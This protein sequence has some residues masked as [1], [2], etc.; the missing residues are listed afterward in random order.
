MHYLNESHIFLFLVQVLLLVGLARGLGI[1]FQRWG[2]PS[3]TAEILVGLLLG[4]TLLGRLAP[5]FQERL[6]P[7]DPLQSAMLETVAWLGILFFLLQTGLETDFNAAWKQRRDALLVSLS[8]LILPMIVGF[9]FCLFLPASYL[10]DPGQ[11]LL[12]ALFIATIMTISALPVTARVLQE[13]NIYKSDQGLLI[14]G[15]LTINDVVGWVIFAVI[16][17]FATEG[18]MQLSQIP[19]IVGGTVLFAGVCLTLGRP[20]TNAVLERMHKWKLP[21]PGSSLTLICLLGVLGGA[22]TIKIGIHALFGFFIIGIMAGESKALSENTRDVITQMVRAFFVPLFFATVGLRIDFLSHFDPV[23]VLLI[24]ALGVAGRFFGAWVGV[25]LTGRWKANQH[26]ISAAHTP[27]GEMQIVVGMLA[28][29]YKVITET[30]FVAV[31]SGAVISSM[32]LGP[33]MKWLL[34][35]SR[36]REVIRFFSREALVPN[37]EAD[38]VEQAIAELCETAAAAS[39]R[40]SGAVACAAMDRERLM[41]T[42]IGSGVAVPHARMAGVSEPLVVM[43]RSVAGVD[44]NAPD[45]MPVHLVFFVLTSDE[46]AGAYLQ[47]MQ[48]IASVMSSPESRQGILSAQGKDEMWATLRRLLADQLP[49]ERSHS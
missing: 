29:E 14:M 7:A 4:P 25:A 21:E 10:V 18:G 1:L 6:F 27:G 8:D 49:Q 42:A 43:G 3:V 26:L 34:R 47:I 48:V 5:A 22:I 2:Q 24:L 46:H 23:L 31:V 40:E 33:W 38:T 13:L 28:L 41:G 15:A 19:I 37:M 36:I 30:V 45:G 16:L 44:W 11:R 39:G 20:V 17:G 32:A 9:L 12:F 35:R